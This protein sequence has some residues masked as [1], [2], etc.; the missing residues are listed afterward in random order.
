[1]LAIQAALNKL[2][3]PCYH[4]AT[5]FQPVG[6]YP[7]AHRYWIEALDAKF[8]GKG[9]PYGVVEF[10]KLLGKYSVN[11]TCPSVLQTYL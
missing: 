9:E 11:R 6:E 7:V 5:S 2:G 3:Y 1:M 10:D 4:L 8:H